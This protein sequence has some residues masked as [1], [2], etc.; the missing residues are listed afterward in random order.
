MPPFELP[1]FYMPYPA[2][3]NPHLERAR[4]HSK[5]WAYEVGI[6]GSE[7][8]DKGA[9][10]WSERK[11][12][13]MDF[14]FF[15]ACTH[16]DAPAPELDLLSEWYVWGWY[17]DDYCTKAFER[18]ADQ[19]GARA[20]VA[21]M[22]EFLPE[23][24]SAPRPEPENPVER[25]LADLWPR[26][27]PTMSPAW[28]RRYVA[29][30]RTLAEAFQ[31]DISGAG[32][33]EVK[34]LDPI[35]YVALRRE[36]GGLIWSSDLV[37]HSLNAEIPAG[38]YATRPIRV[39][40]DIFA[41]VVGLRNDIISYQLDIDDG[42]VNN[43]VVVMA[44]FIGCDL[45]RTVDVVND[46]VTS[47]LYQFENTVVTELPVLF[48]E[49]GLDPQARQ[50]V[51]RYVKALQDWMAGDLE[52]ELR[53][54]GRYIPA[55]SKHTWAPGPRGLGT[56]AARVGLSRSAM[57]LRQRTYAFVPYQPVGPL[58][59]PEIYMPFTTEVNPHLEAARKSTKAWARRMGI[60]VSIPGVPGACIWDEASFDAHDT[61]LLD[62]LC[63]PDAPLPELESFNAFSA[64]GLY[65]DDYFSIVHSQPRDMAGARVFLARLPLFMPLEATTPVPFPQN[66]V[67][68]G[69]ADLWPRMAAGKSAPQLHAIRSGLE[70]IFDSFLWE[71]RSQIENR[72]P[73]PVDYIEMRRHTTAAS[74]ML[75]MFQMRSGCRLPPELASSRPLLEIGLCAGDA[76][77]LV[78]DILSYQ[79]DVEFEGV[80][81][82]VVTI[83]Q[84]LLA[85]DLPRAV[86]LVNRL[87]TARLRRFEHIVATELHALADDFALD[88][89]GRAQLELYVE[90]L[91]RWACGL[92]RWALSI[93]R[94]KEHESRKMSPFHRRLSG[95]PTGL[96]TSAARL[97][98]VLA[99][100]D[101]F[102]T[103]SAK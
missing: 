33:D 29:N 102:T 52:W 74:V 18:G 65:F 17:I 66:P 30:L 78:N 92:I 39:L 85:C 61:P 77:G 6:L 84:R 69:L 7:K 34:I 21:R 88:A 96:G 60:L 81:F 86:E 91:Q 28:R 5:A 1:D 12:D 32:K 46:Q 23:D 48:E 97:F 35:E 51:L 40:K 73:D 13:A 4:K 59:R 72:I 54:G 49:H 20:Y 14:A 90:R 26:T 9:V 25:G 76:S 75:T 71:L 67:E 22:L 58:K 83:V 42:K 47:R 98:A 68:R 43:G 37:E 80:P 79:K 70:E 64:W 3:L 8:D 36:V 19:A 63:Y 99:G 103:P 95:G 55:T 57:G 56:A 2:R 15:T 87:I 50:Q 38:I 31:R 24:V 89:E 11:F 27:A 100:K 53:P 93:E 16:P 94:Y 45:Q 44:H 101:G 62:A 41:D 82:N 10:I